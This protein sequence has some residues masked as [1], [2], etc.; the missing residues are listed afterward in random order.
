MTDALLGQSP[1]VVLPEP[2]IPS[3]LYRKSPLI[4]SVILLLLNLDWNRAAREVRNPLPGEETPPRE[5]R[6]KQPDTAR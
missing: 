3:L 4:P 2:F 5:G 1:T 6:Q